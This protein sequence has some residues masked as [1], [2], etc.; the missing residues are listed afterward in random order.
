[1]KPVAG[2]TSI[3]GWSRIYAGKVHDMYIPVD[4]QWHDGNET[5]LVVASD[6]ISVQDR[7]VPTTIPGKGELLTKLAMWWFERL[8]DIVHNHLTGSQVPAEVAG[9]AMIVRRLRMYPVECTVAGYMTD[10]MLDEYQKTGTVNGIELPAGLREGDRLPSPIFLPARKGA[11][12]AD[13][14]DITFDEFS[15]IVGVDP[16]RLIRRISLAIYERGHDVYMEA[17]IVLA[18]CKLEFGSSADAG[19]DEIILAD[20]V[21]TPD[22][23]TLWLKDDYVPGR[24]QTAMGK[25]FVRRWLASTGW[26]RNAGTPP[27]PLPHHLVTATLE[28]YQTVVKMLTETK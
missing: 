26:D 8:N 5:M 21:L 4:Q 1:M 7:V 23:A 12:E 17:G 14:V 3:P 15:Y 24:S 16:A 11:V 27:P 25:Q 19:D 13:D 28:R 9:R 10:T 20:E 2:S 6:R 22:S 18:T